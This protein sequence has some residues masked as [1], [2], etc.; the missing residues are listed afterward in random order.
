LLDLGH[1]GLA[2]VEDRCREH[3]IRA[4]L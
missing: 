4:R 3:C 2:I 1:C